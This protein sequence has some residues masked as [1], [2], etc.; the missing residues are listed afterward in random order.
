MSDKNNVIDFKSKRVENVEEKRRSFERMVF[1]NMMGTYTV[2]DDKGSCFP[3]TLVDISQSGCMFQIPWNPN[4]QKH[5]ENNRELTLRMY[6]TEKSYLPVVVNI[7][8]SNEYIDNT[9]TYMRYGCQ[10]DMNT[11]SIEALRTFIDFIDQFAEHSV[12]DHGDA[13][14][15]FL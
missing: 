7:M 3:I 9:G 15:Y 11:S 14:V 12:I 2:V 13:K 8:R 5:F 1:K 4:S 6:F 10:F